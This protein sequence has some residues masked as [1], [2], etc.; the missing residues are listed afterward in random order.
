MFFISTGRV[1]IVNANG[2][3]VATLAEG[4]FFGEMGLV[5]S[6][7]RTA[8]VQAT[9]GSVIVYSLNKEDFNRV[10]AKNISIEKKVQAIA[11]SRCHRF[12]D[13]LSKLANSHVT[14]EYTSQ[15]LQIFKEIFSYWDRD[16][17]NMLTKD[18]VGEMMEMLSGKQFAS[19]ELDQVIKMMDADRDGV[20][21]YD[22]FKS[23]IWNLRWFIQ[24]AKPVAEEASP[25][26]KRF[27]GRH[28]DQGGCGE[29]GQLFLGKCFHWIETA[30]RF[31]SEGIYRLSG[32]QKLIDDYISEVATDPEGFIKRRLHVTNGTT[33]VHSLTGLIKSYFREMPEPLFPFDIYTHC[34]A[35]YRESEKSKDGKKQLIHVLNHLPADNRKIL[36]MLCRHLNK[37]CSHSKVNM[38]SPNNIAIVFGPSLLR[39]R[40][41]AADI[42]IG[43][44]N[45]VSGLLLKIIAK[46]AT[47]ITEDDDL[48]AQNFKPTFKIE[49]YVPEVKVDEPEKG[50]KKKDDEH[51]REKER[52]EEKDK[53]EKEKEREKD[54]KEKKERKERE[55]EKAEEKE[56][57][58]EKEAARREDRKSRKPMGDSRDGTETGSEGREERNPTPKKSH[59]D[60]GVKLR[61]NRRGSMSQRPSSCKMENFESID[62]ELRKEKQ[63]ER[64]KK[65]KKNI[66]EFR[67]SSN[68][69]DVLN[70]ENETELTQLKALLDLMK[71]EARV[72]TGAKAIIA[73]RNAIINGKP[74]VTSIPIPIL[75]ATEQETSKYE[76]SP[77]ISSITS[78][79]S[80]VYEIK[81]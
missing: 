58:E 7:P 64:D 9:F 51:K 48:K 70:I 35:A 65:L 6:I 12:Q 39:P 19:H 21:S 34:I 5:F 2:T 20:V 17:D 76:N 33:E 32:E 74:I 66:I 45:A 75:D 53:R 67:K 73:Y 81:K 42:L 71:K 40:V 14:G 8:S 50:K 13:E 72:D 46:F 27:W 22:D 31:K 25:V 62:D 28:W 36:K 69:E 37:V 57:K 61:P 43:D 52:K 44:S 23:K 60:V 26:Q 68:Y 16:G 18:E 55:K 11:K 49:A 47:Y 77:P 79:Q 59:L 78:S 4:E 10:R 15:Q 30:D 38:M 24:P 1:N 56:R 29:Q 54:E 3:V 41:E 63:K 80:G